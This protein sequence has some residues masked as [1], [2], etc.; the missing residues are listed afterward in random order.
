MRLAVV[1]GSGFISFSCV[2]IKRLEWISPKADWR[3]GAPTILRLICGRLIFEHS[4][5]TIARSTISSHL[6]R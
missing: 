3:L 2:A 5:L 6:G 4:H 1:Q